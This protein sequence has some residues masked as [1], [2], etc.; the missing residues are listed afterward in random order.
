MKDRLC[1]WMVV[2]KIVSILFSWY[3][4]TTVFYSIV[5]TFVLFYYYDFMFNCTNI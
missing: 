4:L 2:N 1:M 5:N 3:R